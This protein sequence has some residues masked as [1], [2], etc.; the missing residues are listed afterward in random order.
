[1]S[2]AASR[3]EQIRRAGRGRWQSIFVTRLALFYARLWRGTAHFDDEFSIFVCTGLCGGFG[4]GGTTFGGAYLTKGN[5]ARRVIRHEA[6]HADQWAHFGLTFPF[7]YLAEEAR[8]HGPANK[9]EIEAGLADG[10]YR[11]P[12]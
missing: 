4:R 1:M 3:R 5:T 9:Y 7:R 6:V 12:G 8:R 11:L 10:G 2:T